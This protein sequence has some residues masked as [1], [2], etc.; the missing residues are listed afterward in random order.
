MTVENVAPELYVN[1]LTPDNPRTLDDIAVHV[2]TFDADS[3]PL[4]VTYTWKRNGTAVPSVTGAVF[5][6]SETTRG[7]VII[8]TI[9]ANDGTLATAVDASTTI[10]ARRPCSAPMRRPA[11]TSATP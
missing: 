4:N 1:A 6:A 5:P 10:E 8:V 7:D 11:S 9:T 2:D 3:D